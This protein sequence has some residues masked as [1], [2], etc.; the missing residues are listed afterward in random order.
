M[1][2]LTEN[3]DDNILPTEAGTKDP[4]MEDHYISTESYWTE[5]GGEVNDNFSMNMAGM[6]RFGPVSPVSAT[7][8]GAS[9][10]AFT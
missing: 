6:G 2:K 9:P 4:Y 7:A 3:F 8:S 5:N 10:S 1:H